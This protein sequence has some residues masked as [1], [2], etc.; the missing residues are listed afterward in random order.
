MANEQD[1][2]M[3]PDPNIPLGRKPPDCSLTTR[4]R[5]ASPQARANRPSR[6]R[7][8]HT[9]TYYHMQGILQHASDCTICGAHVTHFMESHLTENASFIDAV[10]RQN[11]EFVSF[12]TYHDTVSDKEWAQEDAAHHRTF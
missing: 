4:E 8:P 12:T 7:D 10:H 6:R 3:D 9:W 1:E 2:P 5:S 11:S